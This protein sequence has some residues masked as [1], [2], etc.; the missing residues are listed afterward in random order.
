MQRFF[1][2]SLSIVIV[3]ASAF[4]CNACAAPA[5][6]PAKQPQNAPDGGRMVRIPAG[7]FEMGSPSDEAGRD[8]DEARRRVT[9]SA[10]FFMGTHEV[11][12]AE[13]T[14]L[15]G[16][17]PSFFKGDDLPVE[18]V[19]WY[20]AAA[21][22]N[23]LSAKEGLTPAYAIDGDAVTWNARANGYR[24]PTEA[25]W[26]YACR[27]G[28]AAPYY[29]GDRPD[30]AGWYFNNSGNR[31]HSVG[32]KTANDWG[33]YDT[34]GN[35]LEWCW[36]WYGDGGGQTDPAGAADGT[37]RVLRGGSWIGGAGI[38]RSANRCGLHPAY[39]F[40]DVGFR[41]CRSSL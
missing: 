6:N 25:E 29:S 12:Q 10:G 8:G 41:V 20:E 40:I 39:R 13:W 30:D 11:T 4:V 18:R 36:D 3:C 28:T 38:L 26:E 37:S 24:L 32:Q 31:T 21:Y 16:S 9:M 34:H 27:A 35:V 7:T 23:A 22:C 2:Y 19:N 14:A 17:N 33:L 5:V 15:M 1:F